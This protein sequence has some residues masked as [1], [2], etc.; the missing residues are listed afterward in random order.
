MNWSIAWLSMTIAGLISSAL[1]RGPYHKHHSC[2]GCGGVPSAR[3]RHLC[4][5]C[6]YPDPASALDPFDPANKK[7]LGY[8]IKLDT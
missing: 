6:C 5:E 2:R 7:A 8:C 1:Q 3:D 4:P